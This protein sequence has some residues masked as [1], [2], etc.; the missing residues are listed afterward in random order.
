MQPAI[1]KRKP[2]YDIA[3]I[4]ADYSSGRT[5]S[6]IGAALGV[7]RQ[8]ICQ[9]LKANN[10]GSEGRGVN[11]RVVARKKAKVDATAAKVL[12]R[13][14]FTVEEYDAH[15]TQFGNSNNLVSPMSRYVHH[16]R[17]AVANGFGWEFTFKSWW[18]LWVDSGKWTSRGQGK[19]V[20]ARRGDASTPFSPSTCRIVT[21]SEMLTDGNFRRRSVGRKPSKPIAAY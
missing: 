6:E 5:L 10:V 16:R 18:A 19:Y 2:S 8:R 3:T 17:N 1:T 21:A 15:V 20:M 14:G 9:I 11:A 13:W 4:T 7:S 12:E